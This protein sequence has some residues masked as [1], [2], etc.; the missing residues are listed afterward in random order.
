MRKIVFIILLELFYCLNVYADNVAVVIDSISIIGNKK[1]KR[2]IMLR[3]LTFSKGDSLPLSTLSSVLEHNRLRLMNTNLFLKA[4]MNVKSWTENNHVVV[5]IDVTENWFLFPIPIFEIADRN[6]NVWWKEHNHTFKRVNYGLRLTY[7][8]LTGRRDPLS[9]LIQLGY[10]PKYSFSYS[11]P[12]INKKQ[13][14]GLSASYFNSGNREIGYA[15]DSNKVAF[16]RD[17]TKFL[18]HRTGFNIGINHNPKLL[19]NFYASMGYSTN[20]IDSFVGKVLNRD[21]YLN[22]QIMQRY[23]YFSAGFSYDNRD[24]RPYPLHGNYFTFNFNKTGLLKSDNVNEFNVSA[25]LAHYFSFSPKLSLETIIKGKTAFV[26]SKQPYTQIRGL[27]YGSDNLRGY[28]LYVVDGLDYAYSKNSFRVELI[29]R[30]FDL[31]KRIKWKLLK[32]LVELPLKSYLTFNFDAG[33]VNN[34]FERET[35]KMSNRQ[36]YGGGVGLDIIAYY[37][38]TWRIEYSINH[39]GEKGLFFNYFVGF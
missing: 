32:N 25:K 5:Q 33:Y 12:Y 7:N 27:G 26:R 3:E 23:L 6:F 36:L 18:L 16:F 28:E 15:T 39:L 31:S 4:K 19:T 38:M 24:I 20:R 37:N 8:N 1:T 30:S 9:A 29:N 13:T 35:N 22:G 34:P 10:T 21:Y 2:Q 17:D 11:L 14:I